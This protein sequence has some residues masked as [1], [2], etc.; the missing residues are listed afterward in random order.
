MYIPRAFE[1]AARDT[2][3][4]FIEANSFATLVT[5]R[6]GA[7]FATRL[8][9]IFERDA[10]PNGTLIGHVAR[11]NPHWRSF[12]GKAPALAMFDGPHAYV[13]PNWYVTSPAVPT[14]N[15]ATVHAYGMPRVIG[16][17][18]RVEAIVD[19]LVAIYEADLARPWSASEVPSEFKASLLKAIVGFEMTIDRIEGKFKF[20]Q[21]RPIEDQLSVVDELSR[22]PNAGDCELAELIRAQQM[23]MPR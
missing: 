7:P 1:V 9:L 18:R 13:S 8:P 12:D 19:R 3:H 6:D 21:N 20:S 5:T 15:Y 23:L 14:W 11:A 16:D 10:G 22:S 17:P 4:A 2:L